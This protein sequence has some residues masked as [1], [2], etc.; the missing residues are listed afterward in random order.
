MSII[1]FLMSISCMSHVDFKKCPCRP[2]ELKSPGPLYYLGGRI[3]F[4]K[5][6]VSST[7]GSIKDKKIIDV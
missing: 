2:V 5:M 3:Q 4:Y 6:Y 1:F 7:C